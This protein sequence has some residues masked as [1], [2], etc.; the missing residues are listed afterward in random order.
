MRVSVLTPSYAPRKHRMAGKN[1][2][3]CPNSLILLVFTLAGL[4]TKEAA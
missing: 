1:A 4:R 2:I 3:L